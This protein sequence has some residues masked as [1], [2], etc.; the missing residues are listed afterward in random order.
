M[1]NQSILSPRPVVAYPFRLSREKPIDDSIVRQSP[2]PGDLESLHYHNAFELGYCYSGSGLFLIDG[3]IVPFQAPCAVM[4]YQGQLHKA[5]SSASHP[6]EWV[7]LSADLSLLLTGLDPAAL[8]DVLP[9]PAGFSPARCLIGAQDDPLIPGLI[10]AVIQ[11]ISGR[12]AGYLDAVR[13]LMWAALL[14]HRRLLLAS[15]TGPA[16]DRKPLQEIG[17]AISYLSAHYSCEVRV[18]KLASL[19]HM[20][21]ASLRRRFHEQVGLSP[22]DY[23]HKLRVIAA[24]VALL[25]PSC[26]VTEACFSVGYNTMS[27]F[28]RQ[29][30]RFFGCSP[31]GW[32]KQEAQTV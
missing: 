13:G 18:P 27:C 25:E 12:E 10:S 2:G 28:S 8:R 16:R 15:R 4:I 21:E 32:R 31:T 30:H 3:E 14:R 26:T 9:I 17:P 22:L 7:F 6:S 1:Q 29:F 11:E 5:Q 20:S 19:C 23:L 24:A